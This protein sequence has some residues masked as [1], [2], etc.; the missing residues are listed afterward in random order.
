MSKDKLNIIFDARTLASGANKGCFRSGIYFAAMNILKE[1]AKHEEL[2]I[3]LY[4]DYKNMAKVKMALENDFNRIDFQLLS[5]VPIN[6][7]SNSYD[8]LLMKR[9]LAKNNKEKIK[10]FFFDLGVR[11]FDLF[12][13]IQKSFYYKSLSNLKADIF[14]SPQ[15]KVPEPFDKLKMQKYTILYDTIPSIMSEYHPDGKKGSW[16]QDLVETLNSEDYY[17]AISESTRQDFLKYF[18]QIDENKIYTTLLACADSFKPTTEEQIKQ[19]KA[20]YNIPQDKKYVFSLCTLEPRKNLIRAVKTFIE[21][22]KKNNIDDIVFVLGGG[23]WKL[24]IDKLEQEIHDLG[25]F[26]DKIL[27]IG[28]VDDEDL[29]ALY[30]GAEWFTYTSQYEGFG[31]PPLEAMN[32]GCPVITSNNSSLPE[33]VNNAGIMIDWDSDEQHVEAYE[34]Y[35]Y[36][37]ELREEYRQKG[38]ENAK[39]FSWA[40][41]ANQMIEIMQNNI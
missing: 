38:L 1:L 40:K 2:N 33:V 3:I 39:Q 11:F 34:K 18:P 17:F 31:L 32:C 28:Y 6:F 23:H 36:N 22:I 12:Q 10:K 37:P 5:D 24:F 27:K 9:T 41:C 13:I 30:S 7:I 19:V 35:Y 20:K 14:F 29:P 16:Y 26:E 21:F 25:K 8:F 4:S 15:A